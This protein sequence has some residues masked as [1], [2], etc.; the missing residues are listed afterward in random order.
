MAIMAGKGKNLVGN[1]TPLVQTEIHLPVIHCM[2]YSIFHFPGSNGQGC[3][4][5]YENL[6]AVYEASLEKRQAEDA[7]KV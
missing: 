1:V 5:S 2:C 4:E 7:N 6:Q 3:P